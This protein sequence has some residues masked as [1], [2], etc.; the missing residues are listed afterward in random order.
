VGRFLADHLLAAGLGLASRTQWWPWSSID[1]TCTVVLG[2]LRFNP[3][4]SQLH[5]TPVNSPSFWLSRRCAAAAH[6]E[7]LMMIAQ[8]YR[9]QSAFKN[10]ADG[11]RVESAHRADPQLLA[12]ATYR[13]LS[14]VTSSDRVLRC[15]LRAVHGACQIFAGGRGL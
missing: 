9:S 4:R 12:A 13:R 14:P 15:R 3:H 7:Q 8:D 5:P 6:T 1:S 11:L 10:A 2:F